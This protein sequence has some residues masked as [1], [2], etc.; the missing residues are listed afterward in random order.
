MV[1]HHYVDEVTE[2]SERELKPICRA[3]EPPV[4]L[5]GGWAVHLHVNDG[6]RDEHGREYVGSRDVDLGVFVDPEWSPSELERSAAGQSIRQLEDAGY[7]PLSFRFVRY[8][9][10]ASGEPLTDDVAQSRPQHEV[11]QMFVDVIPS[12]ADL[13]VFQAVFG[14]RPPAE[15]LLEQVFG[16]DAAAGLSARSP[17]DVPDGVQIADPDLLAAMKVR[18]IP[19]RDSEQKRVKD[20]ADLHALLWYVRD[21]E[22]MREGVSRW[23]TGDER[24]VLSEHLNDAVYEAAATLLGTDEGLLR[25][26]IEQFVG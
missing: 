8:F 24:R 18:S 20:V 9:E 7:V 14:F 6:F 4:C 1:R 15:P 17:W 13:D 23:T 11:F 25:D 12:T 22:S 26:T 5:L 3:A 21:Y 10:R 19:D 2:I 16:G